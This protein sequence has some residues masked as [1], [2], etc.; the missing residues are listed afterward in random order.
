MRPHTIMAGIALTL[1]KARD[2]ATSPPA[3]Q[4]ASMN[5]VAR[6]LAV[7]LA[8]FCA[9][10]NLYSPQALLPL[11]AREFG[12]SAAETSMTITAGAFAVALIA[13]F[14]GMVADMLGRKRVIVSAMAALSLPTALIAA[15]PDI[16]TMIFWRFVQGLMLPPIFAVTIAYVGEEWPPA[17]VAAAAGLYTAGASLGGFSGR[18]VTGILAD[19]IGWRGAFVILAAMALSA[20]VAVAIMLPRERGFVR[21]ESLTA[22]LQQTLR[23]FRNPQLL[24]TFAVGFGTLF[25]FIATFTYVTFLLAAPP[26][27]LSAS[28]L[29]AVFAVYLVGTLTAPLVGVAVSRWGRPR[30]VVVVLVLWAAGILLTLL[31]SLAAIICGLAVCAACGLICQAVSTGYVTLIAKEARSAAVGLYVTSFYVGGSLGAFLPGLAWETAG[32]PASVA[33]VLAMLAIMAAVVALVW[34]RSPIERAR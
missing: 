25:N 26:F 4:I 17:E 31:P 15:A 33:M 6:R 7:G 11:L 24:A 14:T 27:G 1:C 18:F 13:P 16:E 23:H 9:F 21:S 8:G 22:S 12:A 5:L 2:R 19:L 34:T 28:L 10:I 20:A 29:G 3:D 32:W 30:F